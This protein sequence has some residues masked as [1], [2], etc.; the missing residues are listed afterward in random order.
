VRRCI[1]VFALLLVIL[2]GSLAGLSLAGP[3]QSPCCGCAPVPAEPCPCRTPARAPGPT[4]PCGLA[5]T[6]PAALLAAPC[7]QAQTRPLRAEPSPC[8]RILLARAGARLLREDPSVLARPG[9][10]PPPGPALDRPA[11]LSVFRI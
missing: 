9:P 8:P 4:A 10:T 1:Q 3:A 7:R 2:S 5:A 6:A 11:L